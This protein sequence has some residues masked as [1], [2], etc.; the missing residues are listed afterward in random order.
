[1]ENALT[2]DE[3][4]GIKDLLTKNDLPDIQQLIRLATMSEDMMVKKQYRRK[5]TFCGV[6]LTCLIKVLESS[7]VNKGFVRISELDLN[8]QEYARMN[9]LIRF[10]F[11]KR[12]GDKSGEY[13]FN[14]V[15]V[16]SF[17]QGETS[18]SAYFLRNPN[19]KDFVLSEEQVFVDSV[20]S[21]DDVISVYGDKFTE[22]VRG[23]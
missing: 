11:A 16:R 4:R 21:I 15:K 13:L 3:V 20:P 18:V 22:Y 9:D 14:I 12:P 5:V 23:L 19:N 2:L 6:F 1:M 7:K 10:G 8:N 17:F